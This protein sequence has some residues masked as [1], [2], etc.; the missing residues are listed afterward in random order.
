[1]SVSQY[2]RV[3]R[4]AGMFLG[5]LLATSLGDQDNDSAFAILS[6]TGVPTSNAYGN[7]QLGSGQTAL[8]LREDAPTL[9]E[10]FYV[11]LDGGTTIIPAD[12]SGGFEEIANN[13]GGAYAAGDL[14]Y[15]PTYDA[16]N[17]MREA[18]LADSDDPAKQAT[19]VVT[20]TIA[21]GSA[22][23]V[24]EQW[25]QRDVDT[26]GYSAADVPLYLTTTATTTNTSSETRPTAKTDYGQEVAMVGTKHATTGVIYWY[27]GA[28]L[29]SVHGNASLQA[30]VLSADAT[31]RA[32]MEDNYFSAAQLE[33]KVVLARGSLL[34]GSAAAGAEALDLSGADVGCMG[35]GTD[36]VAVTWPTTGIVAKTALNTIAGR[37]L[38]GPAAG[39]SVAD[40]DGVAGDPTLSLAND[41]AA[42]EALAGTGLA[43]R[44]AADT[45]VQRQLVAPAA[46]IT[47]TDPDGVA[48][49]PTFA[50]ANDLAAFEALDATAGL[51]AKTA[52]DTYARRTIVAGSAS[53]TVA[54]GD[55]QA[56][57][58]SIDTAQD[59]RTSA[60]PT[61]AD[62]TLT[63][64]LGVAGDLVVSGESFLAELEHIAVDS[65]FLLLNQSY[66][67]AV[68]QTGGLAVN[69]LPTA[70]TDD[71]TGAGVFTAGVNGV[72]DPTVTTQGAATFAASDIIMLSGAADEG[73]N[74]FFEVVS[75]AANMLTV[76][77]TANG[78]TPRV[79]AFTLDQFTA[80]AGDVGVSITKITVSAL[81]AG[82]DGRWEAASGAVTGFSYSD[83]LL[84]SEVGSVVQAWDADLDALAGLASAAGRVPYFDG[85][86]SA[87]VAD[88]GGT[89]QGLLFGNGAGVLAVGS[90]QD[91]GA[92]T[93]STPSADDTASA[94]AVIGGST[95]SGSA[96][97]T[98]DSADVRYEV[99]NNPAAAGAS[100]IPS[101]GADFDESTW[102]N[103]TQP[104]N[105]HPRN[106]QITTAVGW[107]GG[108]IEVTGLLMSGDD[109]TETIDVSGG[110]GTYYGTQAFHLVRRVRNLGT[111][112]AGTCDPDY[113]PGIGVYIGSKTPTLLEAYETSGGGR[114]AGATINAST[115]LLTFTNPPNAGRDYIVTYSLAGGYTGAGHTHAAGTLAGT[116]H[117]HGPGNH[118]HNTTPPAH[119][120]S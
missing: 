110:D 35:D 8:F 19:H 32:L 56:G 59:I 33:A 18:V 16:T 30:D 44:S 63:G 75:H 39:I 12:I 24:A 31:G 29:V 2:E 49:D 76:R 45:W 86:T 99:F 62:M 46:G 37:T 91:H 10:M 28:A 52:A 15:L 34:R 115:G 87:A 60:S 67:T 65:N 117:V 92:T 4:K 38:T 42:L 66:A 6:G 64:S 73:N 54:N 107:D 80:N 106:M 23:I 105:Q 13:S 57:N 27:P 113:G 71:T 88:V 20:E 95:A 116:G 43:V 77:S 22:G 51:L 89:A 41:L 7:Q 82:T 55:G 11:T 83:L 90:I 84:T 40:G 74:G 104:P 94:N 109:G 9:A 112:S 58:P 1:M 25:V 108:N 53:I 36:L 93:S 21:N 114:D 111:H 3:T 17:E 98:E 26:S 118:T 96:S 50:L 120:I 85:A 103:I 69:Y 119:V 97:V 81:R 78:A 102:G 101:K 70:T 72:S 5:L 61:F 47:I 48:G 68:A 14:V 100:C 79:E